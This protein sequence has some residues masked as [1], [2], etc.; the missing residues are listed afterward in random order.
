MKTVNGTSYKSNTPDKLIKQLEN[1]RVNGYRVR[2]FY[3]DTETGKSWMDEYDVTGTVGRSTGSI[4]RPL[5]INNI[6]SMGGMGIL[7]HCIVRLMVNQCE[8]YR[9][10]KYHMPKLTVD[11][12]DTCGYEAAVLADGEVHA[13]FKTTQ[14]AMN[15]IDFMQGKRFRK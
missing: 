15:W 14:Q 8:V 10:P 5:L 9:H 4:K 3:G 13:R 11:K 2:L 6:R 7:D 12:S 1:A